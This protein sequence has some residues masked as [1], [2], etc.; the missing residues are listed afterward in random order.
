MIPR[1]DWRGF[2]A[3]V[4]ILLLLGGAVLSGS[5]RASAGKAQAPKQGAA[6]PAAALTPGAATEAFG[7][8][9]IGAQPPGN[10]VLSPQSVATALAMAGTGAAGRTAAQIAGTL[11]LRGPVAF[12]AVGNLQRTIAS[13]QAAAAEGHPKA[14]TLAMANGLF[15]QQDFPLGPTFLSG[16]QRHFGAAPEAVDFAG[17]PDGSTEAINSWVS[18]RTNG[19]I[20]EL[21][22]ELPAETR[23]VLANAI[24]LQASWRHPF[25]P[26]DTR[27]RP[28]YAPAGETPAEFMRQTESL[29]YGAGRGYKAVELPYRASTLSLLVVL[30]KKGSVGALQRRLGGGGLARVARRLSLRTVELSI[31]RFHLTTRAGLAGTLE[32]LG[33]PLAFSEAADFSRMTTAAGLKI[34]RVEHVADLAVDEKGTVAAAATGVTGVPTSATQGPR[35]TV[36]FNANRP[37]LFF[38]R[39]RSTGAVLFAGRLT[40]PE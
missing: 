9:L 27:S 1:S 22:A 39:D 26:S 19:V 24:Y 16:L 36:T 20:P 12:K 17:N 4:C 28:F 6:S 14:P 21:F 32:S 40:D 25:D 13:E 2:F 33:M 3:S 8:D 18:D 5:E 11:H 23:L 34:D 7:F 35:D 10:V 29:R 38:V 15:L 37:F 30:P 31:P